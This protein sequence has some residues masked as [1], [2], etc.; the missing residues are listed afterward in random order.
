LLKQRAQKSVTENAGGERHPTPCRTFLA[1][2]CVGFLVSP[3]VAGA[4]S[5]PPDDD[6]LLAR[7]EIVITGVAAKDDYGAR[8]ISS[9]KATAPVLDT[10]RIVNVITDK[11]LA[12]TGSFSLQDALRTVPGITLGAG[13]GG[14]AS[15][16]IPLIRGVDATSDTFVDGARDPGSQTRETFAVDRIEVFKGPDSAFGGRGAAGGAINIVSK[17]ARPGNFGSVQATVGSDS[18]KRVTGDV[19]AQVSDRMALRVAALWHDA[20]VP[21]RNSV[22]DKRRGIS[23]SATWG[24]GGPVTGTLA[25]YHFESDG[26][27]D[28]GIP[29]TSRDQ[30]PDGIRVPADVDRDN[31]YG[32]LARDFQETNVD[33]GTLQVNA[34]L[35]AGWAL[36]TVARYSRTHNDY[37][38]T[39]PDDSAGNVAHGLVWRNTKSRNS[40]NKNLV[41]N[42]NVSKRFDTA[43]VQHNL[44]FGVEAAKSD[45]ANRP[46][47]VATGDRTCP[48]IEIAAHNCT[49]LDHP[50]PHDSW[51]GSISTNPIRSTASADEYGAYAF[52]TITIVP[53]LLLNGGVRWTHF[54]V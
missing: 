20:D 33:A 46:Y 12:D 17:V 14:T 26:M 5:A 48:P 49:D 53:Q 21:G 34:E 24:L 44:A 13:E 4:Q 22:F 27:P 6:Q 36:S 31:F 19:N 45:T 7:N 41:G 15:G 29:L 40:I 16:D 18:F 37:I 23:P 42:A 54:G 30:L 51:T 35:G 47:V 9:P 43:G 39:N 3:A 50:D 10:P 2:S 8:T 25:Y 32:L 52:D 28:Y 1:L 38:V 11:V